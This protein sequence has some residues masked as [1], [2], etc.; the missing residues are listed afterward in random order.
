MDYGA[1]VNYTDPDGALLEVD[2]NVPPAVLDCYEWVPEDEPS[3]FREWLIPASMVN[4]RGAARR[5]LPDEA[6]QRFED[7]DW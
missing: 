3:T 5:V 7:D 6:W 2:L 1:K 4:D